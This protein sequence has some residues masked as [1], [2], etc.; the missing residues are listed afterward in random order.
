MKKSLVLLATFALT[1]NVAGSVAFA[2]EGAEAPD[3]AIS[4]SGKTP[5]VEPILVPDTAEPENGLDDKKFVEELQALRNE[6]AEKQASGWVTPPEAKN[7]IQEILEYLDRSIL[8]YSKP[9]QGGID[10]VEMRESLKARVRAF[11]DSLV[12]PQEPE[13]PQEPKEP[14]TPENP[15]PELGYS[16]EL[17]LE[18]SG[19]SDKI[20][21]E[22]W[23]NYDK[24]T[25]E[26]VE[27][28]LELREEAH[29]KVSPHWRAGTLTDDIIREAIQII[30]LAWA[31]LVPIQDPETPEQPE[32]PEEPKKPETPE[33]PQE[34]EQ[35]QKPEEP[36]QPEKPGTETPGKPDTKPGDN[37][38]APGKPQEPQTP[39]EPKKPEKPGI[40]TPGK[41]NQPKV[42]TPKVDVVKP[43]AEVEKPKAEAT[44]QPTL[45][46]TGDAGNKQLPKTGENDGF[47]IFGAAA[48][49]ILAGVGMLA[50]GKRE[51]A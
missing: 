42:E 10:T 30:D 28:A 37:N 20:H 24:Y 43:S 15:D 23:N 21:V 14:E 34:P 19:K 36:K 6:L 9:W 38:T 50:Y 46:A 22:T 16:E 12:P 35:P 4:S 8:E 13:K 25:P 51:D 18:Y 29:R 44:N 26:S 7:T 2:T 32:K 33:K 1:A 49:T 40:E 11:I 17:L 5:L 48:L 3:I 39:E 27:K 45:P 47:A 31:A 41:P